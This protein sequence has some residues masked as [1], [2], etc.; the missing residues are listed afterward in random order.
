MARRMAK[1]KDTD[2]TTLASQFPVM[3]KWVRS[4]GWIEIG[5]QEGFGFVARALDWG[6]MAFEDTNSQTLDEAMAVLE[7]GISAYVEEHRIDLA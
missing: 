3:S 2:A 7:T 4:G 6:G 5:D 1:L